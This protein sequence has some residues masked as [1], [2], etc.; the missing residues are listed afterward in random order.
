M[1]NGMRNS[2]AS[3]SKTG[4]GLNTRKTDSG[5]LSLQDK[6]KLDNKVWAPS[7]GSDPLSV[8]GKKS[9]FTV[10]ASLLATDR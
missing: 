4:S 7:W 8:K 2:T 9:I 1:R 6:V 10:N 5:P 3:V